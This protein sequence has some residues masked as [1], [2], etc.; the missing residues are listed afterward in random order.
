MGPKETAYI[1]MLDLVTAH[2][3][4]KWVIHETAND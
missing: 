3:N 2:M 4:L 1:D